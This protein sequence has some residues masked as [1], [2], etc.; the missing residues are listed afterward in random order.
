MKKSYQYI[1]LFT[2][3]SWFFCPLAYSQN[4]GISDNGGTFTPSNTAVLELVSSTRG[5]LLPRIAG[6]SITSVQGLTLYNTT[7][8][9]FEV[10]NGLAWNTFGH[11]GDRNFY[12]GNY[13]GALGLDFTAGTGAT[14]NV[15]VGYNAGT[16]LTTGK[17]F[18]FRSR[19]W[20]DH[21]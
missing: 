1:A 3:F 14:D 11:G 19:T 16:A 8:K 20:N 21:R 4:V 9:A 15:F 10:Y 13:S 7:R 6:N 12:A 18:R 5:F 17:Y 2:A